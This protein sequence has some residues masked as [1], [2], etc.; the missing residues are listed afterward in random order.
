MK[1]PGSCTKLFKTHAH[2]QGVIPANEA[3]L[4]INRQTVTFIYYYHLIE[5]ILDFWGVLQVTLHR[6][7]L[8]DYGRAAEIDQRRLRTAST[9]YM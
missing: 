1:F 2:P 7:Y 8:T 6:C 5:E 3:K 9:T 4:F